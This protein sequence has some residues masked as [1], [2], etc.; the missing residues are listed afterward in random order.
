[1]SATAGGV[2][3]LPLAPGTAGSAVGVALWVG[4]GSLGP[5]AAGAGTLGLI[6]LAV[7]VSG[8]AEGLLDTRDDARIVIDEVAGVVVALLWLPL[9]WEVAVIGFGLF[10]LFDIA[11]PPPCRWVERLP[12]GLGVVSDDLVAGLYANFLGQLAFRVAAG[13]SA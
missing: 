5:A 9:R 6:A 8:R 7:W 11:K 1:M 12:G 2:G 3:Y 4:L 10:R 13:G